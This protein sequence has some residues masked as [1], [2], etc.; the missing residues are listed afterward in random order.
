MEEMAEQ[1][2]LQEEEEEEKVWTWDPI[3]RKIEAITEKVWK[4]S[5]S[6]TKGEN[7]VQDW[8]G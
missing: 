3:E 8:D 2:K 5:H 7:L 4:L 6:D 1:K